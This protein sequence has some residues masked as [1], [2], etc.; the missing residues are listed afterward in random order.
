MRLLVQD[1]A[2]DWTYCNGKVG[3]SCTPRHMPSE[4]SLAGLNGLG[5]LAN[6]THHNPKR[7]RL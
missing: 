4:G 3:F 1:V 6:R 5:L 2:M 7:D